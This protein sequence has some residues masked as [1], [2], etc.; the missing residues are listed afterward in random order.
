L[1]P[2]LKL[3]F[4][5]VYLNRRSIYKRL[6]AVI[7]LAQPYL[8]VPLREAPVL[9][10]KPHTIAYNGIDV[11]KFRVAMNELRLPDGLLPDKEPEE[12]WAVFAG[13]LGPSYDIFA[14]L[15][16]AKRLDSSN[17]KL[18]IIIAG[19]GPLRRHVEEYVGNTHQS[20]L[21]YVGKLSPELLAPLYKHCDIGLC[22]YSSRSNVEMPD[23]IYDYT[24]AGLAVVN[25]LCG[26]VMDVIQSNG[27]GLQ[28][29][30]GDADDLFTKLEVLA[31]DNELRASMAMK[32][33]DIGLLYDQ[34]VQYSKIVNVVESVCS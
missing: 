20:H 31:T 1:R 21:Y 27:I 29:S 30:G 18:K 22:A 23:K 2:L 6:D 9:R 10:S 34:H 32:S 33:Y 19:D 8:E 28:Y 17:S 24:A 5:P 13:S 25:S 7:A 12:V 11:N 14:L 4:A 3:L 16:V 15:D 26:E